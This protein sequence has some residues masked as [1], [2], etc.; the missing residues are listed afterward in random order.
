ML[1]GMTALAKRLTFI[2]SILPRQTPCYVFLV[3]DLQNNVIG[4]GAMATKAFAT[5]K[6]DDVFAE[7]QPFYM[8]IGFHI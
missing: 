8:P 2:V 1:L 5:I 4:A 6:F 3:M 7:P